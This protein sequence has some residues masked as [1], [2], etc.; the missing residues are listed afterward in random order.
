MKK[1]LLSPAGDMA[2][3]KAA[4][5]NGADAVY[6][7]GKM[8]G[9]RKYAPNF[10]NEELKEAVD[11]GHLY[12]VK[13]YVTV[14]TIIYEDELEECLKYIEYLYNIGVDAV[15]VQDLG[16]ILAIRKY[17]KD[18]EIH[19]STQAHTHNIEQIKLLESLGVKRVVLAR[20]MSIE[21]INSLKT[22]MELEVFIHGALCI[23]YSGECLFSSGLLNRSGNRGECA[24]LCRCPYNLILDNKVLKKNK[25]LL[26]PKEL[27]T[28]D[29]VEELKKSNITSFKIEGRM[30][31]PEYVGYVTHIYRKL[32]DNNHYKLSSDEIFNLK[33]LY[34]R[35]FTK[36]YLFSNSDAE[37]ISFSS[38]NHQGVEIG[39][40][41]D[42]NKDKIK[43]KLNHDLYQ[44]DAIRL[45]D[46]SG[47]YVNF[48][49][50][51]KGLLIS[52]ALSENIIYVDN[53]VHLK[54]KGSVY[55]TINKRLGEEI[56]HSSHK[57][58]KIKGYVKGVIGEKLVVRYFDGINEVEYIAGVVEAAKSS[59]IS[60][61]RIKEILSQLGDTPFVV[62]DMILDVSDFI[63][64]SVGVLKEIKRT[65]IDELV[66]KRISVNRN[67]KLELEKNI[68]CKRNV[69]DIKISAFARTEEQLKT[70][71]DLKVDYIY[72]SDKKLYYKYKARNI[73]LRLNRVMNC[74]DDYLQENLLIG[75]TGSLKYIDNNEV[76][77]DYYLNVV[78]SFYLNFLASMGVKRITLSPEL[79]FN[80]IFNMLQNYNQDAEVECLVYGTL[81][82][83][84][85]KYNFIKNMNLDNKSKY[86]LEDKSKNRFAVFND[87]YTHLMGNKII[88][89][90]NDIKLLY[91]YGVKVFRLELFDESKEEIIN[92][93]QLIRKSLEKCE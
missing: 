11:L 9:A 83:M 29:Y 26:S 38:S 35:G 41:I 6:L 45:P 40:V 78:N 13:I 72:V 3:L 90:I 36:G 48:L 32:L 47:M 77:T 76:A 44:E 82:Y 69:N 27:N 16:L 66:Q 54:E 19:A 79:S 67:V 68:S 46:G 53:K 93:V 42:V 24:G 7:A 61:E 60:K 21:E 85:M 31:S 23:S 15:I 81:E 88:N 8:F 2:C 89:Y 92:L 22:N 17:F 28:T 70:L 12:G 10:S 80:R 14:N 62:E 56:N 64:I 52:H 37:F 91:S 5:A 4:I 58:I 39:K 73:Y 65:L 30:K 43:I 49:Y 18:L 50:N 34:N 1:E 57:R 63:F 74:Y 84:I 75:E 86:Y 59:P 55:L 51:E 87:G 25:Y 71:L 33:S 20:E